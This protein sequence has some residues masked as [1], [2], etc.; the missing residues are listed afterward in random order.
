[1]GGPCC[2]STSPRRISHEPALPRCSACG[3]ITP[4][5][6]ESQ[7][8]FVCKADGCG[9]EANADTNAA[10]SIEHTAGH[11][12]SGRGDLGVTRS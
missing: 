12:V 6:R 1:M 11:A 4:G 3:F 2:V 7:A 8:R 9:Y 5:S 10:R